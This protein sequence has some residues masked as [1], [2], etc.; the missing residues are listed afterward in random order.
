MIYTFTFW[1]CV[2][3][4][5]PP[6]LTYPKS[7]VLSWSQ[8]PH[9]GKGQ[10]CGFFIPSIV[11]E[12]YGQQISQVIFPSLGNEADNV[13]RSLWETL[14]LGSHI[15]W[16]SD[17]VRSTNTNVL[18]PICYQVLTLFR[19]RTTC[20]EVNLKSFQSTIFYNLIIRNYNNT[21]THLSVTGLLRWHR[22]KKKKKSTR[23]D[24]FHVKVKIHT[25][26]KTSPSSVTEMR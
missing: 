15:V 13:T 19:Y 1:S 23:R 5:L 9:T 21:P 18:F 10:K 20:N 25:V 8:G 12:G 4:P 26:S 2:S 7:H 14:W 17:N 6:P 3:P 24:L 16:E 22:W 11:T